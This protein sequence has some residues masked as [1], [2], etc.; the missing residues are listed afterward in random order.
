VPYL[1]ASAC[2]DVA[3]QSCTE[4]CPVDARFFVEPL[5]GR[6]APLGIPSGMTNLGYLSFG[7]A[8]VAGYGCADA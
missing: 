5:K 3:A 2:I 4:E 6:N 8:L 7:T 1:I